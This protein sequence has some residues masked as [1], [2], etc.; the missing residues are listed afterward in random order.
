MNE[1]E[2][3]NKLKDN[4]NSGKSWTDIKTLINQRIIKIEKP[5]KDKCSSCGL[6][7]GIYEADT[8]GN[9][10]CDLWGVN[11]YEQSK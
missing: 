1:I 7:L 10:S 3:L 9:V 8:C 11:Q 4:I 5:K 6:D 2:F